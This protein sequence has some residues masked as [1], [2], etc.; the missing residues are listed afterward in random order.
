MGSEAENPDGN[1]ECF[2]PAGSWLPTRL[3]FFPPFLRLCLRVVKASLTF[4]VY[5]RQSNSVLYYIHLLNTADY[6][7]ALP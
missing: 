1:S 4:T 6:R 2:F 5:Q 3:H 7:H